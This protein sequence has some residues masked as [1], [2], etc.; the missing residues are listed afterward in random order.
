[1]GIICLPITDIIKMIAEKLW[2]INSKT[3]KEGKP[4]GNKI[5]KIHKKNNTKGIKQFKSERNRWNIK[6]NKILQKKKVRKEDQF[7]EKNII[8]RM[9]EMLLGSSE[10]K[11]NKVLIL[12]ISKR[13]LTVGSFSRRKKFQRQL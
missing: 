7:M 9:K 6:K 2:K 5:L 4:K 10:K 1:M 12:R 8:Q 11:S 13:V 3:Y